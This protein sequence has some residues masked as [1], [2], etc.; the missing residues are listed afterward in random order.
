MR[1]LLIADTHFHNFATFGTLTPGGLN[2]RLV[3]I[4]KCVTKVIRRC[5]DEIAI[6]AIVHLGDF[7]HSKDKLDSVAITMGVLSMYEFTSLGKPI[8]VL[9]GNH[10][11]PNSSQEHNTIDLLRPFATV[12]D[13][14]TGP[15]TL[16]KEFDS[17]FMPYSEDYDEIYKELEALKGPRALLGHISTFGAKV[18]NREFRSG[19]HSTIFGEFGAVAL[20]H[21]HTHQKVSENGYYVGSLLSHSFKQ[22]DEESRFSVLDTETFQFEHY[23]IKDMP[24]F[25][26][27]DPNSSTVADIKDN[28]VRISSSY[29]EKLEEYI[30]CR[31]ARAVEF[32]PVVKNNTEKRLT[33]PDGADKVDYLRAYCE[34]TRGDL[35]LDR[36]LKI[37]EGLLESVDV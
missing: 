29:D 1:L 17:V 33:V 28:Y 35:D 15:A 14:S 23:I 9:L 25:H 20:G 13:R 19:L 10:D 18:G 16:Y 6:D 22:P 3:E 2:S 34:E 27:Y 30:R 21:F 7:M 31:G 8:V 5:R 32:I 36:L 12:V 26:L 37:G 4:C 24:K 11:I